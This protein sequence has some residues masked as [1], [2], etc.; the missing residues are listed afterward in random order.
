MVGSASSVDKVHGFYYSW[1][2]CKAQI[3]LASGLEVVDELSV[4]ARSLPT[5]LLPEV[6]HFQMTL[7]FMYTIVEIAI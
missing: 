6:W 7:E 3:F 2:S 4:T 1:F 5:N